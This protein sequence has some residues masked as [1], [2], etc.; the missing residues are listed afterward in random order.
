MAKDK[1]NGA[2]SGSQEYD[3]YYLVRHSTAHIMATAIQQMF[4][5]AKFAIGPPIKDGFYYDFELPRPI[6][7]D[8]FGQI[9]GRMTQIVKENQTFEKET[10][11][12]DKA[13]EFFADQPYKLEIIDR[14]EDET[15]SIYRNGPFT[16]LCAGPHVESTGD[17]ENF[18]LQKV[19][20]AYWKGDENEPMLQRIYGTAFPTE[21]EL[22]QHLYRLEEAKRRDHRKLGRKLGLFDFNELSPGAVFWKPKGWH[23]Y[24]ALEGYFR[25]LEQE[26]GYEEICNPLI[27]RKD[28]FEQS[29]HWEHYKDNMFT[30]E[31]HE[32]QYFLKP[33]NC[34][35]TMVYFGSDKRSYRDLPMRVAEFGTLHRNELPG[36]LSGTTR[37]RQFCQDDAH[38]FATKDQIE[39]E[40]SL[41]LD[42][43]D[44]TYELFDM[45]YDI[46]L[47]TRPEDF[48]GDESLWD[49]AEA[50]LERTLEENGKAFDIHEGDGA[51][52]GPKIDFQVRDSLGRSWQ[53][54]TIQLDFQLPQRFDLTYTDKD[55]TEKTPIVIHRALAGSLERFI[56]IL[57]EHLAG[58]FPTW[59]APTQVKIMT[60][61]DEEKE[62][63]WNV[64]KKLKAAGIRVDVDDRG[65]KIGFKIRE[66]ETQKIP[67]MLVI[68]GREEEAGEVAVR[69]YS[70]GRR[71]K[72]TPNEVR[73]EILDKVANRTLDVEIQ[74][75]RIESGKDEKAAAMEER[76]Y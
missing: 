23:I 52:Y 20:G 56:G 35:D 74:R 25:E 29:G 75:S 11:S 57:V 63:A 5:D 62:Y 13:R 41:L 55:N 54:A 39:D 65:E 48:M 69:S 30:F 64:A 33:M 21:D 10:W 6:S 71:G 72:M 32:Q 37:V 76:G 15:V 2:D 67:Y 73:D 22:E 4:P 45:D 16:D 27:Y 49:E 53:C 8:D 47:S 26:N 68:G 9:E 12:K 28:L 7:T 17:C 58:V 42:M 36:V 61:T 31:A 59:L 19:A 24:R 1:S 38:I 51:F 60:I 44:K 34:P 66:A 14:I 43:V 50:A 46:E 70:E 3:E 40:I 18:K